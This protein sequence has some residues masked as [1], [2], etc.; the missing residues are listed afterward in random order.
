MN[1]VWKSGAKWWHWY[2]GDNCSMGDICPVLYFRVMAKLILAW[3]TS[4]R[5]LKERLQKEIS[6][7]RSL[8]LKYVYYCNIIYNCPGKYVLATDIQTNMT[9][10]S[11]FGEIYPGDNWT[12]IIVME[13]KKVWRVHENLWEVGGRLARFK[14]CWDTPNYLL[15]MDKYDAKPNKVPMLTIICFQTIPMPM[16]CQ[17]KTN[18]S[19][20]YAHKVFL[21]QWQY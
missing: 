17:N 9:G 18:C 13:I 6:T 20:C 16:S 11:L 19:I 7:N 21:V 3:F 10:W 14:V 8:Y 4:T 1:K 15:L 5:D 12:G 2:V